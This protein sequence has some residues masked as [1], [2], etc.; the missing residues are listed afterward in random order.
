LRLVDAAQDYDSWFQTPFGRYADLLEKELMFR[1]IGDVKGKKVL[2][3][4][5]GTGNFSVELAKRGAKVTGVDI[6][7]ELLKTAKNKARENKLRIK[8]V[9]SEIEKFKSKEKFDIITSVAACEFIKD[10]K[11]AVEQAKKSLKSGGK[12]VIGTL[13]KWSLYTILKKFE[14]R[15]KSR[16]FFHGARFYSIWEIQKMFKIREWAS[17]LFAPHFLPGWAITFFRPLEGLLST[18]F[19]PLGAFLVMELDA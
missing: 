5:C 17:T 9:K 12:I 1:F 2:D 10:P 13:N 11:Q 15:F 6:S 18:I 16:S 19:S 7:S 8:F 3:F 14:G 4:G